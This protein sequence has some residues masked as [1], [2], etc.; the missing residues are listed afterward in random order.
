MIYM[1]RLSTQPA[2]I[3]QDFSTGLQ[4]GLVSIALL[5][6]EDI[7]SAEMSLNPSY[8]SSGGCWSAAHPDL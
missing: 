1:Q 5:Q 3:L 6:T 4:D 2:I 8:P 7:Y